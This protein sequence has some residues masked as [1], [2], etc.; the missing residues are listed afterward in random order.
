MCILASRRNG[1]WKEGF[2][3]NGKIKMGNRIIGAPILC[4][5]YLSDKLCY[6]CINYV[7]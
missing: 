5:P 7:H 1:A 2:V 3:L 6:N 4:I